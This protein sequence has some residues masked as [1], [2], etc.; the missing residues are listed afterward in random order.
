MIEYNFITTLDCF[1]KNIPILK[2]FIQLLKFTFQ[3]FCDEQFYM[4]LKEDLI[5]NCYEIF[6]SFIQN[7]ENNLDRFFI[8]ISISI[9]LLN[10]DQ[11]KNQD[12]LLGFSK[13]FIYHLA[14][15]YSNN[16]RKFN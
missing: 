13:M 2:N 12:M 16:D 9:F 11:D 14:L 4:K 15:I 7:K 3:K 5:K 6:F 8:D 10:N 1:I